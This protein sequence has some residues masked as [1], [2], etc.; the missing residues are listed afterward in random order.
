MMSHI[1]LESTQR[2]VVFG[3]DHGGKFIDIDIQNIQQAW[4]F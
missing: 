1:S 4:G 3:N 2:G